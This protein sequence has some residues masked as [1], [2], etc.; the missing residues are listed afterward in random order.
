MKRHLA[1]LMTAGLLAAACTSAANEEATGMT[2]PG[3]ET[4][5]ATSADAP[6][7][8]AAQPTLMSWPDLTARPLPMPTQ[9]IQL[10]PDPDINI[11]DLWMPEGDGPHPV[12]LMIHGG[13]WQKAIAD[14]TLMNYAAEA[15]RQDGLAV[16]NIEYRGVDEPGGGYPG[17]FL[18]VARAVDALEARGGSLGLDTGRVAG[19]GHSAGG[20]LAVWAAARANLPETSPLHAGAPFLFSGVVNSGGLADLE[21]SAPVTQPG[22]LADILVSL[23]GEPTTG[24]PDVFSDTSPAELAPIGARIVSVN[25]ALDRIAPPQLGQAVTKKLVS[26]GG[27]AS[28]VEVPAAGHVELIAPGTQAFDVEVAQLKALLGVGPEAVD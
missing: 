18:D 3:R 1:M 8:E 6:A 16:W 22:C 9:T 10:G 21:A 7:A 23:T 11:V 20:H 12:V 26:A 25:G 17:T 28:F 4:K 5:E 19:F 13:C 15:L 2:D 27:E 24:R 14:R